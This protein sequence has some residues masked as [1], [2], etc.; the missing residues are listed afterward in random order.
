MA[1]LDLELSGIIGMVESVRP[2][3]VY[4]D[5]CK[6][7]PSWKNKSGFHFVPTRFVLQLQEFMV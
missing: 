6:V 5:M 1:H 3:A 2:A 4:V 7:P